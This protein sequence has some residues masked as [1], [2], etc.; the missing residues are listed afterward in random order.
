MRVTDYEFTPRMYVPVGAVLKAAAFDAV[1][2]V[3]SKPHSGQTLSYECL[4]A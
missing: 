3:F 1:F 4:V 2:G